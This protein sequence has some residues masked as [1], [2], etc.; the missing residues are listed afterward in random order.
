ML[1]GVTSDIKILTYKNNKAIVVPRNL[2]MNDEKGNFVFVEDNGIAKKRYVTNGNDSGIDYE[3]SNGLNPN[4][5]LI[6]D[7]TALLGDG[8]KIK[9]I[10]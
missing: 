9:V 2:I 10:Q 6:T 7:G 8:K 1:C 5:R 3:I 4:D